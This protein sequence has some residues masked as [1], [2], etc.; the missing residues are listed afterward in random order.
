MGLFANL[1]SREPEEYSDKW[2]RNL[3]DDEWEEKREAV[4]QQHCSGDESA[5]D[6]LG[7][8]DDEWR[9]RNDNGEPWTPPVHREHG[10][11]LP[12]DDD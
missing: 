4:R 11:Y 7:R 9:R 10:W 3:S 1:F 5:W 12:D 8:F 6:L 2:M